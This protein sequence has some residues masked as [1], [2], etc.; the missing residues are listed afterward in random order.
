[1]VMTPVVEGIVCIGDVGFTVTVR[2]MGTV[3]LA[4]RK[5]FSNSFFW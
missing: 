3:A 1:M 5:Q 2:A 4:K